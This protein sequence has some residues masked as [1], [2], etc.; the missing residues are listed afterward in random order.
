MRHHGSIAG[1]EIAS[2]SDFIVYSPCQGLVAE[3]ADLC[4]AE[5]TLRGKLD[6]ANECN[7][8]SDISVFRWSSENWAPAVSPYEIQEWELQRNPTRVIRFP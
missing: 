4:D 7:V 5:R 8:F 3:C 1:V 6:E 2:D